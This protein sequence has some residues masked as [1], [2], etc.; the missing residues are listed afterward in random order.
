M[1]TDQLRL[2]D[3]FGLQIPDEDLARLKSVEDVADYIEKHRR[4]K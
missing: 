3:E 1:S 2:V 4:K